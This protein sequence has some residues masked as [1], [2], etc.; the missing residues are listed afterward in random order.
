VFGP[1]CRAALQLMIDMQ[2]DN[3]LRGSKPLQQKE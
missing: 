2:G 1:A 3:R